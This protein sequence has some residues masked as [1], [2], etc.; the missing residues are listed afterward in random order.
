MMMNI[1]VIRLELEG[2]KHSILTALHEVAVGMDADIQQAVND[3]CEQGH[4]RKVIQDAVKREITAA[5]EK[6][7]ASYFRYGDGNKAIQEMVDK[8]RK[9]IAE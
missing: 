8:M 3:F 9:E 6:N 5:I 7:I 2:M 1:P 4:L